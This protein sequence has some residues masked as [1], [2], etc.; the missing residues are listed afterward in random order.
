MKSSDAFWNKRARRYAARPI[1][2]EAAY[3]KTL[4]RVLEHL[5]PNDSVLE[6][7]CGTGTTAL[8]LAGNVESYLSTDSAAGMIEIAQEKLT[9][10]QSA[11]NA[12]QGLSFL[13][14]DVF[15]P[16]I[17]ASMKPGGY[18]AILAFNFLHLVPEPEKTLA[19]IVKL[20][21]PGGLFISKTVCIGDR[22]WYLGPLVSVMKLFGK[23]PY[24]NFLNE[25]EIDTMIENAGFEIIE[26]GFFPAPLGRFAVARVYS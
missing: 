26:T 12:P 19:R 1:K 6:L 13:T 22:R 2:D 18:D 8:K 15:D 24:V 7:G 10:E 11:C 4:E 14:A 21:K 5:G 16:Q 25:N 23:A 17:E 9:L 3:R 20:L